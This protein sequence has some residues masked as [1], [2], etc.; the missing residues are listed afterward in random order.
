LTTRP[1]VREKEPFASHHCNKK[2]ILP[3][4]ATGTSI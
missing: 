4:T 1:D 3:A 2:R